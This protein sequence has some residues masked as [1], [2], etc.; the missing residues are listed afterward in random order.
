MLNVRTIREIGPPLE[1]GFKMINKYIIDLRQFNNDEV[2]RITFPTFIQCMTYGIYKLRKALENGTAIVHAV[3]I[4]D[5]H[6]RRIVINPTYEDIA[7]EAPQFGEGV[8][9]SFLQMELSKDPTDGE[10]RFVF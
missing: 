6:G 4:E 1:E 9:H 10:N 8:G 2:D 3:L 5:S 7:V